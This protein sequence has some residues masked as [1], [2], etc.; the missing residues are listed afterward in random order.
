[1]FIACM[2]ALD[3]LKVEGVVDIFQIVRRIKITK[4]DFVETVVSTLLT[5]SF[6]SI[7][8]FFT[9]TLRGHSIITSV[10]FYR[11]INTCCNQHL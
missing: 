9:T 10:L 5:K 1:M 7:D 6:D 11:F 4:P 8:C 3:Q 2:N